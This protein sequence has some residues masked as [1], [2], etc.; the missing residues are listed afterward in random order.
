VDDYIKDEIIHLLT[1]PLDAMADMFR[2]A[3]EMYGYANHLVAIDWAGSTICIEF[4]RNPTSDQIRHR[5]FSLFEEKWNGKPK[6]LDVVYKRIAEPGGPNGYYNNA[7]IRLYVTTN[8][9]VVA[10]LVNRP[11]DKMFV[12][13]DKEFSDWKMGKIHAVHK[14]VA[15]SKVYWNKP[16]GVG[17]NEMRE[18]DPGEQVPVVKMGLFKV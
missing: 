7:P 8:A 16:V 4:D 9:Q 5:V 2:N 11:W 14:K 10:Q 17:M 13:D 15:E 18:V 3:F 12:L 1:A 6:G